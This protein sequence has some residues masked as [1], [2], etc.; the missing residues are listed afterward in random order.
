MQPRADTRSMVVP[1]AG[2]HIPAIAEV[3]SSRRLPRGL[4]VPGILE[5]ISSSGC[6]FRPYAP[7]EL[8]DLIRLA[9]GGETTDA[10]V[11]G[12]GAGVC[13][14]R[15]GDPAAPVIDA[16]LRASLPEAA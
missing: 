4:R 14:C 8:G 15:F 11:L 1:P 12:R 6:A 7:L 10:V 5:S 9:V 3:L 13:S 16:A 2:P